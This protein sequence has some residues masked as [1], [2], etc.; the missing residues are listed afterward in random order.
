MK[1]RFTAADKSW[2]QE[3]QGLIQEISRIKSNQPEPKSFKS[4][5][6]FSY[7]DNL[8]QERVR[9]SLI[10]QKIK[11]ILSVLKSLN[12]MVSTKNTVPSVS[13]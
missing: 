1:S 8:E 3:K 2:S 10:E 11:E 12:S 5:S 6:R 9:L 7:I 13:Y 4:D